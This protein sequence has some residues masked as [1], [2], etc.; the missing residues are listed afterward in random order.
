MQ[1]ES[2]FYKFPKTPHLVGSSTVDDDQILSKADLK[3]FASN[4]YV[5]IQEKVD[6]TLILYPHAPRVNCF[7]L[8]SGANV[9]VHFDREWEP[10]IQKR[11]GI[12]G[13]GEKPQ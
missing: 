3:A 12:I 2:Q 6:G 9:G 1:Q 11:G 13:S 10:V 5:V 4:C 8:I 7:S